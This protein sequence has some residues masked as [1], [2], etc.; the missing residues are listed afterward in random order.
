M[1]RSVDY[2][3]NEGKMLVSNYNIQRVPTLI[4]SGE[5]DK[6][7]GLSGFWNQTGT[8]EDGV[9]V[10]RYV[11]PIYFDTKTNQTKGRVILINLVDSS[12]SEC[13]NISIQ[14]SILTQSLGIEFSNEFTYDINS[15]DGKNVVNNYKIEGVPTVL[16]SPEI[17]VYSMQKS[18]L[19]TVGTIESDGWY[20]FRDMKALGNV[21]Y[22]NLTTGKIVKIGG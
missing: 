18:V 19:K 14:K 7:S 11:P 8:R 13:Y 3:S 1:V 16:L 17:D 12:C 4:V 9:F 15:A 20:V 10:L 5:L 2:S 21:T 22:E 6:N